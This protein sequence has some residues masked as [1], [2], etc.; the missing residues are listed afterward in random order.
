MKPH[1]SLI[2]NYALCRPLPR[3][4]PIE[5]PHV[6]FDFQPHIPQD[7]LHFI[8]N[9]VGIHPALFMQC[10]S[11]HS[12]LLDF[13]TGRSPFVVNISP[14]DRPIPSICRVQQGLTQ[15]H[16]IKRILSL[17]DRRAVLKDRLRRLQDHA[18]GAHPIQQRLWRVSEDPID[19]LACH[20][21]KKE[22]AAGLFRF[23]CPYLPSST[24]S[25]PRV[26]SMYASMYRIFSYLIC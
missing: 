17:H 9:P 5:G 8:L 26:T 13:R 18:T 19:L 14:R 20:H 22:G 2:V 23:W 7:I 10:R 15:I 6:T 25:L 11:T 1:H 12:I 16:R 4:I 21:I 24:V 3:I